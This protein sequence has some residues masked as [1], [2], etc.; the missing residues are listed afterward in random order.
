MGAG[1]K[2]LP[3]A[4]WL[5]LV[6]AVLAFAAVLIGYLNDRK[7]EATPLGGGLFMLVMAFVTRARISKNRD[8]G[9]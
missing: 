3:V 6:A 1:S 8:G 9:A 4:F 2:W 7:I 5:Y